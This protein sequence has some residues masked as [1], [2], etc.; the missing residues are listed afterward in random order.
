[1]STVGL[2]V[3]SHTPA[4]AGGPWLPLP[5]KLTLGTGTQPGGLGGVC[6]CARVSARCRAC[7]RVWVCTCARVCVCMSVWGVVPMCRYGC[8]TRM[9]RYAHV[10][11]AQYVCI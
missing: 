7:L 5:P 2:G 11:V 6:V 8:V 3:P 10:Y 4:S 9:Y 1:M